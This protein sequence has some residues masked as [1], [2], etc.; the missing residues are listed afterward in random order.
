MSYAYRITYRSLE[1]TLTSDD[2]DLLHKRLE[3]ETEKNFSAT[4]R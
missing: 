4:I 1:R 2:V 3:E